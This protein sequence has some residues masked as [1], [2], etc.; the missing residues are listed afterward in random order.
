MSSPI[1]TRSIPKTPSTLRASTRISTYTATSTCSSGDKSRSNVANMIK[2]GGNRRRM[3]V[4]D[5]I[6][7]LIVRIRKTM[8]KLAEL[9]DAVGIDQPTRECRTEA[10]YIHFY[11]LLD[12]IVQSEE[13][14][15]D[16][17]ASDIEARRLAVAD[18]RNMFKMPKFHEAPYASGSIALLKALD[19]DFCVLNKRKED[20]IANQ[21][22]VYR[23]LKELCLKLEIDPPV[24]NDVENNIFTTAEL[25]A[26]QNKKAEL[27]L[28]VEKRSKTAGNLQKKCR[29]M[30]HAVHKF[31]SFNAEQENLLNTDFA[32]GHA[33]LSDDV[34]RRLEELNNFL[35]HEYQSWV[36]QICERYHEL[37]MKLKDL[38]H[39]CG[40]DIQNEFFEDKFD[41][42]NRSEHDVERLAEDVDD[43]AQR[44]ENGCSVF[45]KLCKWKVL[46]NE[47][48]DME[49]QAQSA[50]FYN[51]RG[52]QLNIFLRRQKQLAVSLPNAMHELKQAVIMYLND[53]TK[54]MSDILVEGMTPDKY[55]QCLVNEHEEE[56][57]LQRINK[58]L[59]SS[60][61]QS[62]RSA[63]RP[64][65]KKTIAQKPGKVLS[66]KVC[67]K[68]HSIS[69]SSIISTISPIRTPTN[70]PKTSSPKFL[71]PSSAKISHR[72][73]HTPVPE[74][75]I[76]AR[77]KNRML[78]NSP[79]TN[80]GTP[81]TA[82]AK[83]TVV[84]EENK[85]RINTVQNGTP[86][87]A[88]KY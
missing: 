23:K 36:E 48:L 65:L 28:E 25:K 54:Q 72:Q 43:L 69:C 27:S 74:R 71:F 6:A 22:D 77:L 30:Y 83:Y 47:K 46:W 56:K 78:A 75:R 76:S 31:L 11:T 58:Q 73:M 81:S 13:R 70:G 67:K 42:E 88:W 66:G 34:M 68:K 1:Q 49:K 44:Y 10:A 4:E 12:D 39:K 85:T 60:K 64:Q 37:K 8:D 26:L 40:G 41:P 29:R 7:Q 35:D 86:G 52:G 45:D 16:G 33:L 53:D 50:N 3:S 20:A 62:T 51:N 19:R 79:L 21:M 14:M 84:E 9:W 18:L 15:V 55:A 63:P 57:E 80:R 5:S 61:T 17:V 24:R 2:K 59:A 82:N 38:T 32:S 87:R